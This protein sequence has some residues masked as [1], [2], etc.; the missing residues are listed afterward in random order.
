MDE[1]RKKPCLSALLV[2]DSEEDA[3]MVRRLADTCGLEVE[4]KVMRDGRDA[5]S[6]LLHPSAGGALPHVVLLDLSLPGVSGLEILQCMKADARLA[7]IP[8][9]ILSGTKREDEIRRG[10]ILSAHSHIAKPMSPCEFS[11][12]VRSVGNY[13]PRLERLRL[14]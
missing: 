9:I 4:L 11:W 14:L 5:L 3:L 6:F 12:I 8:V 10:Q 7:D 2:E 13:W 1:A